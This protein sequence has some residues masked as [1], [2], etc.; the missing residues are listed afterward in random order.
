MNKGFLIF[1]VLLAACS[2]AEPASDV[3][4]SLDTAG[5][6]R[7][8]QVQDEWSRRAELAV[9]D[10]RQCT[11]D[12]EC[13]RFFTP[14]FRCY[15]LEV[16]TCPIAI[17]SDGDNPDS[18]RP[19]TSEVSADICE[20][21]ERGCAVPAPLCG[22]AE[23]RCNQGRCELTRE[24]VDEITLACGRPLSRPDAVRTATPS[25]DGKG[26]CCAASFPTCHCGSFGG[27]VKDR[28]DCGGRQDGACDLAPPDWISATDEHGCG[29]YSAR[30]PTTACC[31]CPR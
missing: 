15:G 26:W 17:R 12:N 2:D 7:C 6:L 14:H 10:L 11:S 27:F 1:L 29:V 8:D 31:N 4:A 18:Q 30:S 24:P 28:C 5:K 9:S 3:D 13:S 23:A 19:R 16:T 22:L 20:R 21:V 25:P